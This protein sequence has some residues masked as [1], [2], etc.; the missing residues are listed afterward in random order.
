MCQPSDA[1]ATGGNEAND[2]WINQTTGQILMTGYLDFE[3]IN[4]YTLTVEVW[5]IRD[6]DY[7]VGGVWYGHHIVN[8]T[9]TINV[10]GKWFHNDNGNSV[11]R[12]YVIILKV[13][14]ILFFI[15][16]K[17]VMFLFDLVIS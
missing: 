16:Q 12:F 5:D 2:F 3:S 17:P 14:I 10:I 8:T 1:R 15:F 6:P 11:F 4:N 9:V 13:N 7:T